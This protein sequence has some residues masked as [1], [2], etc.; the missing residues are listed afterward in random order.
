MQ[1]SRAALIFQ[2][3]ILEMVSHATVFTY[4]VLGILACFSIVSLAIAFAKWSAFGSAARS[5]GRFLRAFRKANT[6]ETV[7]AAAESF[8]PAPL[9][10]VFDAGYA[11]SA[12]QLHA[13]QTTSK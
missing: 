2:T 6:L 9:V 4:A 10:R 1:G 5:D 13:H 8:R 7:A 3:G 12:R 11:E